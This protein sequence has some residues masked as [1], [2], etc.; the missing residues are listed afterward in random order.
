[1]NKK[2]TILSLL[3]ITPSLIFAIL[4][5]EVLIPNIGNS[6]IYIVVLY[7]FLSWTFILQLPNIP[8]HTLFV[9]AG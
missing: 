2:N 9:I 3:W 8:M 5:H 4:L 6:Y 7:S 1:M